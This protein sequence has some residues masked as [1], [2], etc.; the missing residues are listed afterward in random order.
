[1]QRS[2]LQLPYMVVLVRTQSSHLA[3]TFSSFLTRKYRIL[4]SQAGDAKSVPTDHYPY[5]LGGLQ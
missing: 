5:Q 4:Y 2:P 3:D 1:M